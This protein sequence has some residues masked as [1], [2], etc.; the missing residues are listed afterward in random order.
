VA[1][2]GREPCPAAGM[3]DAFIAPSSLQVD[4]RKTQQFLGCDVI[5]DAS[6]DDICFDASVM[7]LPVIAYDPYLND[8]MTKSCEEAVA[9]RTST[10]A[11]FEQLWR[12]LSRHYCPTPKQTRKA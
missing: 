11:R 12:T 10:S 2:A 8:L 1:C 7:D 6:V 5:F 4:G 3:F 9:I